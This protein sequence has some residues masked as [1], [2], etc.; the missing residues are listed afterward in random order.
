[1][2]KRF[3][4][5]MPGLRVLAGAVIGALSLATTIAH[6]DPNWPTR[7][8]KLV[9][10]FTPGGGADTMARIIAKP[11]SEKLGQSIVIENKPGGGGTVGVASALREPADGYT[12]IWCTPAAQYLAPSDL[13]YKPFEDLTPVSLAVSA[14]YLLVANPALPYK[15]LGEMIAAAKAKPGSLNYATAGAFGHGRMMG[16]YMKLLAGFEMEPIPFAG[17]GPATVAIMG[18]DVQVGFISSPASLPQVQAGKLH[19]LANTT[20][21]AF[22]GI[23]ESI[24]PVSET[25]PNFDVTAI[26]YVAMRSGT[27]D[28]IV[29]RA[30]QAL[31]EVLAMPEIKEQIAAFGVVAQGSTPADLG[32]RVRAEYDQWRDVIIRAGI[33]ER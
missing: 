29:Q 8:I 14:T 15:T 21:A 16:E 13:P 2:F 17:E 1:M 24:R 26:N 30:S 12:L 31:Q 9:V 28:D 4:R 3:T 7:P 11:L 5:C 25:V 23:P 10:G 27:P 19:A 32:K 22:P 33:S 20:A 6:A 18:G